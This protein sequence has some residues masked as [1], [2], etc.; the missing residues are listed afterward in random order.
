MNTP[1]GNVMPQLDVAPPKRRTVEIELP[2]DAALSEASPSRRPSP[3]FTSSLS[4]GGGDA[5][6]T[7]APLAAGET[8]AASAATPYE[9]EM[10]AAA[11]LSDSA[12]ESA[13][14]ASPSPADTSPHTLPAAESDQP[15]VAESTSGG[16]RKG[17]SEDETIRLLMDLASLQEDLERAREQ[18]NSARRHVELVK[19]QFATSEKAAM[20]QQLQRLMFEFDNYRKRAE[21]EKAEAAE[22]SK[23]AVLLK[24]L[25]VLDNLERALQTGRAEGGSL[26][27]FL[28]GVELIQRRLMDDLAGFGVQ[29][30]AAVGE[31]FDP[32]VHEAIATD[33]TDEYKPN[34]ILAELKRGYRVG[35]RLLRPAMVRVAVR[36]AVS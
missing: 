3:P 9:T 1:A 15:V 2:T 32:N 23:H 28:A 21:R 19:E 5:F 27:D 25:D 8:P 7:A 26:A 18:T 34:T 6:F 31:V 33:E 16:P 14:E 4:S 20:Q 13:G 30:I 17:L 36:P 22:R 12:E 10:G 29:P 11:P 35:D 24:M